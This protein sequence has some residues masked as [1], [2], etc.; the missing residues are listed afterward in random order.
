MTRR[1]LLLSATAW[2][3]AAAPKRSRRVDIS[4]ISAIS[5]E[6]ARSPADAIAFAKKYGMSW[7]ELRGIPGGGGSYA[8]LPEEKLRAAATEFK[9]N[10]IRISFLDASLL[11]FS[12]PGTN[13]L[14]RK[15]E[16][17][18]ARRKR[19]AR[20]Q[21]A[22]DRRMEDLRKAIHA[23]HVLGT[24]KI[25]LF[26]F[27]RVEDPATVMP[28]V[29]DIV[30]EMVE[31]AGKDKVYL[32][33]E[34]EA[35]CNVATC[36]ELAA[37]GKLIPS[38]WFG[39]NWDTLNGG[40]RE[41]AFPDGYNL[42]PKERIHNIHVK[43]RALLEGPQKQD[44]VAIFRKTA[45]DGYRGHYGLETHIEIGRPGQIPA[46]HQSMQEIHRLLKQL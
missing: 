10:G 17:E 18:E 38:K 40:V 41:V 43:G 32:L 1:E 12:L 25:R 28:R 46:S 16:T 7:L 14:R 36:A 26:A 8:G 34:N 9:E 33:C 3:A 29:A 39:F 37:L 42:L 35:S 31:V 22:F 27:S 5:D 4:R 15:N 20:D 30:G 19:M 6:L 45:A 21:A 2:T 44:W 11:K 23:A 13:P 24:D